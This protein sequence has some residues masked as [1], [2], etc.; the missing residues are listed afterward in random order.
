M[1]REHWNIKIVKCLVVTRVA[2]FDRDLSAKNVL[3]NSAMVAK[4]SDL[5]NARIVNLQPGQLA[6]TLSRLPGTLVY[7]PPEAFHS[8]SHYGPRLD[9]F[10]CGHLALFTITQVRAIL[11]I[12]IFH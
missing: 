2:S 12:Q 9:I 10:A 6:Q 4:I 3:L 8:T 7:M 5:G 11:I 1:R